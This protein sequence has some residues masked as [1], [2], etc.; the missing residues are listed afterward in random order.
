MRILFPLCLLL[1]LAACSGG[2]KKTTETTG[3]IEVKYA[4]HFLLAQKDG[5]VELK[6]LQPETGDVERTFA[7]VKA[8]N[9][10]KVPADADAIEVPVKNTAV[11]ST[12]H[13][14]M[15]DVIGALDC[16]KGSTDANFVANKTVLNGIKSGKIAAF[17]DEVSITPERLLEKKI[18]LV[19]ISGFGKEFP[20]QE[21]LQRLGIEVMA[22]YEW[23]EEHPLGKAEWVKVFGHLTGKE[24]EAETHFAQVEK[25]YNALKAQVKNTASVHP[26]VL[27]GSLIGDVWYAPAGESYMARVLE[28]GGADYIY[29]NEKGTGSCE[30]TLEQVFKDQ[31]D[32]FIWINSGAVTLTGLQEQQPKYALFKAFKAGNVFCYTHNSNYFWEMSAANPHWLLSDFTFICGTSSGKKLHFYR[33][34]A[35]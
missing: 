2:S 1:V 26:K 20:N 15:L 33:Q 9:K 13:I 22:N 24:K 6:I 8:E 7:L 25:E 5:Y 17:T 14:G 18:S 34:L 10:S 3:S 23:R 12:T 30:H 31:Q 11:L 21:K 4:R 27:V 32:A 29:R 16:I 35:K 19:V 28:D